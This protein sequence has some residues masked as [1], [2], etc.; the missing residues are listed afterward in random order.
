VILEAVVSAAVALV[1]LWLALV[2]YL[3]VRRPRGVAWRDAV[4]M[5]PDTI[6]LFRRLIADPTVTRGVRIRLAFV[7]AYLAV[8]IDVIPDFVPLIG[9]ADDVIVV[10]IGLRLALR[11]AG[12]ER[13]RTS[14]P[15]TRQGL[16]ALAHLCALPGLTD[17]DA[18]QPD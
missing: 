5:V 14:W 3:A 17:T 18:E 8:P 15:G 6:G 11:H 7:L 2:V 12:S 4:R 1:L 9:Y 13:V 16:A 10:A